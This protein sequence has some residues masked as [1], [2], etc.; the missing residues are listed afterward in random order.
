M[1]STAVVGESAAMSDDAGSQHSADVD[2]HLG[3]LSDENH[4]EEKEERAPYPSVTCV[5]CGVAPT[6]LNILT[7]LQS[8]H[9]L[10]RRSAESHYAEDFFDR[11]RESCVDV[12]LP[13]PEQVLAYSDVGNESQWQLW[14]LAA[15]RAK[16]GIQRAY[17]KYLDTDMDDAPLLKHTTDLDTT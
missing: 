11:A 9:N 3:D 12:Q 6:S 17:F 7:L 8:P 2:D 13:C 15:I 16:E 1:A 14:T 10:G 4:S 5:R